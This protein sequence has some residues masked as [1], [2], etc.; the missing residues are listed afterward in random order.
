MVALNFGVGDDVVM[1]GRFIGHDGRERNQPLA[2]FGN[3]AMMPGELV[4]DARGLRV[5][6]FLVE[7]RSLPGFSGSPVFVHIGPGADRLDAGMTPFY[8]R[9]I[10]LIGIDTGHKQVRDKVYLR[11]P[12]NKIANEEWEVRQNSG[13]AIIAP[14]WRIEELLDQEGLVKQRKE[15][16]RNG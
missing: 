5:E 9:A 6:A 4:E 13:V 11:G 8:S 7:M 10:G 15:A 1:T 3:V 16:E 14:V 2:R 12:G